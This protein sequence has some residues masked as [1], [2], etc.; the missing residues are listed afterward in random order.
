MVSS[1]CTSDESPFIPILNINGDDIVI[2]AQPSKDWLESVWFQ[3][4]WSTNNCERKLQNTSPVATPAAVIDGANTDNYCGSTWLDAY[5]GCYLPCPLGDGDCISLGEGYTC[6]QYTTCHARIE[7]GEFDTSD[8]GGENETASTEEINESTTVSSLAPLGSTESSDF[9]LPAKISTTDAT[10]SL[11]GTS[12]TQTNSSTAEPATILTTL[13]SLETNDSIENETVTTELPSIP[14]DGTNGTETVSSPNDSAL[15]ANETVVTSTTVALS[16]TTTSSNIE[17]ST[18][19]TINED[20]SSASSTETPD[21]ATAVTTTST[22]NVPEVTTT[23]SANEITTEA[24]GASSETGD[25]PST[26]PTLPPNYFY[27]KYPTYSPTI[28]NQPSTWTYSPSYVPTSDAREYRFI[29]TLLALVAVMLMFNADGKFAV[30]GIVSFTSFSLMGTTL[31]TKSKT[32]QLISTSNNNCKYHVDIL[33]SKCQVVNIDAPSIRVMSA[34]LNDVISDGDE[35][36][37]D[38]VGSISPTLPQAHF[39]DTKTTVD[40]V[41]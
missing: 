1:D 25:M 31:R 36:A 6:H 20:Q 12:L 21:E 17:T 26:R 22:S 8:G 18:M 41:C 27:Y 33:V 3:A 38:Y 7:N 39:E 34:S 14:P 9:T 10:F 35:C 24:T 28:S 16:K 32:K 15:E 11:A 2:E 4:I 37:R 29:V 19:S 5:N 23:E 40:A 13:P 30:L